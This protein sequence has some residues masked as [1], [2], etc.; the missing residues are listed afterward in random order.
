MYLRKKIV[1]LNLKFKNSK[2]R[3]NV[4]PKLLSLI[5]AIFLWMYVI[6][7][8]NPELVKV[9]EN[10]KVELV[11]V[12]D[13]TQ[14]G[15]VLLNTD[16]YYVD[17]KIKGRRNDVLNIK[18]QDIE[19]IADLRGFSK[20]VVSV[21]L[22]KKINSNTVMIEDLSKKD[23]KITLDKIVEISKKV[24]VNILGSIPNEYI[25][26]DLFV[27]PEEILV[28]G[29][30][31]IVNKVAYLYGE[32]NISNANYDIKKEI[33]VK[34]VDNDGNIVNGISIGKNYVY[35]EKKVYKTKKIPINLS[36]VGNVKEGFKFVNISYSP[37][38]LTIKGPK[39]VVDGIYDLKV[40]E[41][42]INGLDSSFMLEKKLILPKGVS[43]LYLGDIIKI[44]VDIEKI[45]SKEFSYKFNEIPIY[46]LNSNYISNILELQSNFKVVLYDVEEVLNGISKDDIE[47]YIDGEELEIGNNS[48]EI[49]LNTNKKIERIE[50]APLRFNLIVNEQNKELQ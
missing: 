17:V 11:N 18:K 7:Q 29:P 49:Q 14:N 1:D 2:F 34:P 30:E 41:I 47:P 45:V 21:P 8:V 25:S 37:I 35:V 26:D 32:L 15:L 31:T 5:F 19:I 42:N 43:P 48:V 9:V 10:V 6:D 24:N 46:N 40:E 20:G 44:K 22:E 39:D 16:D 4:M 27:S 3:K 28:R 12:D 50:I 33:P 38:E 13:I 36:V 23:V